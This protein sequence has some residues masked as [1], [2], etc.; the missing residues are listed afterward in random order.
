MI[1]L[2]FLQAA[3]AAASVNA[4]LGSGVTTAAPR[5]PEVPRTISGVNNDWLGQMLHDAHF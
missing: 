3:V 2:P 1:D 5:G 4:K